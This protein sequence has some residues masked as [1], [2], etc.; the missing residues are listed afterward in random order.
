MIEMLLV[1][2]SG[3]AT[4]PWTR[5]QATFCALGFARPKVSCTH[6]EHICTLGRSNHARARTDKPNY[7]FVQWEEVDNEEE[8]GEEEGEDDEDEGE[9]AEEGEE[10]ADEG[11]KAGD[12]PEEPPEGTP[13]TRRTT[14]QV[15]RAPSVAHLS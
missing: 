1:P 4:S 13:R 9:D 5:K 10:D 2:T 3:A 6:V 7:F 12:E 15:R 8:E 11:E 14:K